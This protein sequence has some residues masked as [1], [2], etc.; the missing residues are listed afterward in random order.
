V[1]ITP[2]RHNATGQPAKTPLWEN[3][4]RSREKI[5]GNRDGE[6]IWAL[7]ECQFHRR[8]GRGALG[9]IGRKCAGKDPCSK[10]SSACRSTSGHA[11]VKGASPACWN[12]H[13]IPPGPDRARELS[14]LNGAIMGMTRQEVRRKNWDEIVAFAEIEQFP[15]Y[16]VNALFQ[17]GMY[18]RLAFAVGRPLGSGDPGGG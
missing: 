13:R 5:H 4:S 8:A 15:G 14:Y 7:K 6:T 10:S 3:C 18:V 16:P 11:R 17:R 1:S 12:R 2:K 9:I